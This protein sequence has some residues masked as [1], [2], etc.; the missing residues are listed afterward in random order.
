MQK[1]VKEVVTSFET[2][3]IT[4]EFDDN[5][6]RTM[7]LWELAQYQQDSSGN[8]VGLKGLDGL[9]KP[10]A[11]GKVKPR[12]TNW[13][14][15]GISFNNGQVT[16]MIA[17]TVYFIP[18]NNDFKISKITNIG[19]IFAGYGNSKVWFGIYNSQTVGGIDI[20][21]EMLSSSEVDANTGLLSA[22]VDVPIDASSVYWLALKTDGSSNTV[23]AIGTPSNPQSGPQ[24]TVL[25]YNTSTSQ[26]IYGVWYS[27]ATTGLEAEISP[28]QVF[29]Q[30]FASTMGSHTPA[31]FYKYES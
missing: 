23:R 27:Y 29:S 15:A 1:K 8:I 13:E 20:P 21:F 31:I 22:T 24:P 4:F 10:L 26:G 18:I 3:L 30:L 12:H 11:F 6:T 16:T 28:S 7:N 19:T 2:G 5:S 9:T 17:N 14:S 25:G